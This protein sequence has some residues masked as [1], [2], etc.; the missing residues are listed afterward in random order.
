MVL[1]NTLFRSAT[2]DLL[3]ET[4]LRRPAAWVLTTIDIHGPLS[5]SDIARHMSLD[6]AQV[7][8][9]LSA[10]IERG[11]ASRTP[12]P[13]DSRQQLVELTEEGAQTSRWVLQAGAAG[14]RRLHAGFTVDEIEMLSGHL[15]RLL[16]NAEKLA[17]SE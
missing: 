9:A 10:L 2:R 16:D 7:S 3:Q 15:D 4:G 17:E 6:K 12:H 11:L 5:A 14:Q 8:R 1:A 13:R